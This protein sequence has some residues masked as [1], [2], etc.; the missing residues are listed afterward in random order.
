MQVKIDRKECTSCGSCWDTCPGLFEENKN[1]SFSQIIEH[2][3]IHGSIAEGIPAPEFEDCAAEASD[4]CPVQI[5][6]ITE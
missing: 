3:R 6:E 2:Y 5:I 4:S 1:D